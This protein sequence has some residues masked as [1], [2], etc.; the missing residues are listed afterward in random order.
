MADAF[1]SRVCN[2]VTAFSWASLEPLD[3]AQ[4]AASS[5]AAAKACWLC[6]RRVSTS[7]VAMWVS[8]LSCMAV[9]LEGV[10]R[11]VAQLESGWGRMMLFCRNRRFGDG[12]VIWCGN[13]KL[14]GHHRIELDHTSSPPQKRRVT[15]G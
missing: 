5:I 6:S 3:L 11:I 9:V 7:A 8:V 1:V 10:A 14:K 4:R 2:A 15:G 12:M 13:R